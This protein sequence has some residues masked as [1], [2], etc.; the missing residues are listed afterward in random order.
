MKRNSLMLSVLIFAVVTVGF[1]IHVLSDDNVKVSLDTDTANAEKKKE[2]STDKETSEKNEK[3]NK[4][5][6]LEA[7]K[8]AKATSST[9]DV[10][11]F[12][13]GLFSLVSEMMEDEALQE[14]DQEK[15]DLKSLK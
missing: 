5:D 13:N 12:N 3:Q 15:E 7:D 11:S 6:G 2:P 1:P 9:K 8:S 10:E 4:N 14:E